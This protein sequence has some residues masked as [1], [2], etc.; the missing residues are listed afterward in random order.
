MSHGGGQA[1]MDDQCS[2]L[3]LGLWS[4]C[5]QKVNPECCLRGRLNGIYLSSLLE[6]VDQCDQYHCFYFVCHIRCYQKLFVI[7]LH[8]YDQC[9]MS[10][11]AHIPVNLKSLLW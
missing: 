2:P 9:V 6:F 3:D 7:C 1:Q 10:L 5:C 8:C 4:H 11:V